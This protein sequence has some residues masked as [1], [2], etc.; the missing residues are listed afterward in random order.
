ML[1]FLLCPDLILSD[2]TFLAQSYL[3]LARNIGKL[4]CS[5]TPLLSQASPSPNISAWCSGL[6]EWLCSRMTM[7]ELEDEICQEQSP[8][9]CWIGSSCNYSTSH[10]VMQKWQ[11]V[12]NQGEREGFSNMVFLGFSDKILVFLEPQSCP[13][14]CCFKDSLLFARQ[15]LQN[16]TMFPVFAM[17]SLPSQSYN[18]PINH[19]ESRRLDTQRSP[20]A[21]VHLTLYNSQPPP[22]PLLHGGWRWPPV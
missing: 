5:Y 8:E 18:F 12:W 19:L 21:S 2:C 13:L 22:A 3:Q 1:S 14:C 17:L 11:I 6:I 9:T 20:P 7:P 10:G 4:K 16:S 15:P